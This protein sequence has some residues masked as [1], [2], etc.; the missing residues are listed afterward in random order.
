MSTLTFA[1]TEVMNREKVGY[2]LFDGE[3][4]QVSAVEPLK[5]IVGRL[6]SRGSVNLSV[7]QN[8]NNGS[9]WQTVRDVSN[10]MQNLEQMG[11]AVYAGD[12]PSQTVEVRTV[13]KGS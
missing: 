3:L 8:I 12:I 11:M 2:I 1:G 4:K 9:T 5:T 10:P 13:V 6:V 7:V